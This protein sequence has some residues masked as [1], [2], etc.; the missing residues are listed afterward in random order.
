MFASDSLECQAIQYLVNMALR[1]IIM[2]RKRAFRVEGE[3]VVTF[4][5]IMEWF[6]GM[7]SDVT[8]DAREIMIG[9]YNM[10]QLETFC[11]ILCCVCDEKL[12][13]NLNLDFE[14]K[15]GMMMCVAAF[16]WIRDSVP[17]EVKRTAMSKVGELEEEM[18]TSD[19]KEAVELW[20]E[21]YIELLAMYAQENPIDLD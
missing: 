10:Q 21:L 8:E 11:N 14:N 12:K 16:S 6:E 15:Y 19:G 2:D 13:Y 9:G 20:I 4:E 7:V 1:D 3:M 17:D 5:S 18:T